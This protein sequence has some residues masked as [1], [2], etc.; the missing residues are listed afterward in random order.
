VLKIYYLRNKQIKN[1]VRIRRRME[2]DETMTQKLTCKE[3]I[4][5]LIHCGIWGDTLELPQQVRKTTYEA[6]NYILQQMEKN[7]K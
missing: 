4:E 3:V 1:Q 7:Y 6:E 5:H 2:Q